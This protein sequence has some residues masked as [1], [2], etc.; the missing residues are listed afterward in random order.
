MAHDPMHPRLAAL[1][2]MTGLVSLVVAIVN[3]RRQFFG[4]PGWSVEESALVVLM[5]ASLGLARWANR[6]HEVPELSTHHSTTTEFESFDDHIPTKVTSTASTDMYTDSGLVSSTTQA[7]LTSILGEQDTSHHA[8]ISEA[9]A[10]IQSL[11]PAAPS[12]AVQHNSQHAPMRSLHDKMEAAPVDAETGK[13]LN[14]VNPT[15][16]PL[17]GREDQPMIDPN[18]I[19]GLEPN[20]TFVTEGVAQVPL[21]TSWPKEPTVDS[22]TN[23]MISTPQ[24]SHPESPSPMAHEPSVNLTTIQQPASASEARQGEIRFELDDLFP[25]ERSMQATNLEPP[26]MVALPDS[27]DVPQLPDLTFTE[28]FELP[29]LPELPEDLTTHHSPSFPELDDLF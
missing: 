24:M 23:Q 3:W 14:R 6:E 15:P 8:N 19:K 4:L 10:A 28:D 16:V 27:D 20:R 26:S 22:M 13:T 17:P 9:F 18:S 7:I 1:S 21:P 25:E 5:L 2:V 29:S 12:S 11:T